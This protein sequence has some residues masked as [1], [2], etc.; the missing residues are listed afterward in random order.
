M[1][2]GD[3]MTGAST[4][5]A[6]DVKEKRAQRR[7]DEQGSLKYKQDLGRSVMEGLVN[8]TVRPEFGSKILGEL[9]KLSEPRQ[10]ATGLEGFLGGSVQP[11]TPNLDIMTGGG[12]RQA[13]KSPEEKALED[14]TSQ[15]NRDEMG[16][17]RKLQMLPKFT[18]DIERTMGFPREMSQRVAIK[19]LYGEDVLGAKG[20]AGDYYDTVN[21]RVFR[22][23][24]DPIQGI[25]DVA[26][27]TVVPNARSVKLNVQDN[28]QT[29]NQDIIDQYT[30]EILNTTKGTVPGAR[31]FAPYYPYGL[32]GSYTTPILP[33]GQL[34]TPQYNA[35]VNA[36][37]PG[38]PVPTPVGTPPAAGVPNNEYTTMTDHLQW[39]EK[40]ADDE[41]NALK[42]TLDFRYATP[43]EVEKI[44]RGIKDKLAKQLGYTDY[45]SFLG[46]YTQV[47]PRSF[48]VVPSLSVPNPLR[49]PTER[50]GAGQPGSAGNASPGQPDATGMRRDPQGVQYQRVPSKGQ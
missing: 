44:T 5:I 23:Q 19:L 21:K 38:Q 24:R 12:F 7:E 27:N 25:V 18:E 2:L 28:W 11:E 1:A 33:G 47:K 17:R 39:I 8:G 40:N 30:G 42:T 48:N 49:Q 36:T 15:V 4:A 34:G 50:G 13:F 35:A 3:F 26:T 10:P 46:R 45:Q 29:G 31:P 9:Q 37:N 43:V 16:I 20:E 6:G 32:P 41:V 14:Y 22:G